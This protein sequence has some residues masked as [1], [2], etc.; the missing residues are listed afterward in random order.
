MAGTT[1]VEEA[2]RTWGSAMARKEEVPAYIILKDTEL[3]AIAERNP[4]TLAGLAGCRGIGQRRLE[5]WGDEILA[6]LDAGRSG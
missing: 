2:L 3:A 6:V 5:L 1:N 4:L